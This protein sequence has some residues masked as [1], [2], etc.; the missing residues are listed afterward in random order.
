MSFD[1]L[2]RRSGGNRYREKMFEVLL[3]DTSLKLDMLETFG[4][5]MS[6]VFTRTER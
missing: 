3:S 1:A 2:G 5:P 4:R 6:S